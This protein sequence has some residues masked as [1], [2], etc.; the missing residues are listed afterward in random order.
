MCRGLLLASLA[1]AFSTSNV[2]CAEP[3]EVPAKELKPDVVYQV[4]LANKTAKFFRYADT[5]PFLPE[6]GAVKMPGCVLWLDDVQLDLAAVPLKEA[7]KMGNFTTEEL[8]IAILT[9]PKGLS[10]SKKRTYTRW[11]RLVL[12][13][14]IGNKYDQMKLPETPKEFKLTPGN[15][16][17]DGE[18]F[19]CDLLVFEK[20]VAKA[21][22]F[23]LQLPGKNLD[24]EK[25][26]TVSF[27]AEDLKRAEEYNEK[28]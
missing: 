13:D 11:S 27:T 7:R 28:K 23:T 10:D 12:V 18:G 14:D 4:R 16:R 8:G 26:F 9:S 3:V 1:I 20:P 24:L 5:I 19:C 17:I 22:T 6:G 21:K 25:D 15:T 2:W